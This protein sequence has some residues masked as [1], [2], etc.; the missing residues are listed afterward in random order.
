MY[1][2]EPV[3]PFDTLNNLFSSLGGGEI[4]FGIFMFL[5]IMLSVFNIPTVVGILRGKGLVYA[6]ESFGRALMNMGLSMTP[7]TFIF[8]WKGLWSELNESFS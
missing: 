4:L 7:F 2:N 1:A 8:G 5:T 3:H 6:I